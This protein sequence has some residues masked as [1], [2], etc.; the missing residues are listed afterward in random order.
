MRL[1]IVNTANR[2][3]YSENQSTE[4]GFG[5][6]VIHYAEWHDDKDGKDMHLEPAGWAI[7][8]MLGRWGAFFYT[9]DG[10]NHVHGPG[11]HDYPKFEVVR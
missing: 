11:A 4:W 7:E 3:W 10:W 9:E 2:H 8:I 1:S 6:T 5:F